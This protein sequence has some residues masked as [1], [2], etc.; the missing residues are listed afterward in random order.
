[1]LTAGL[2]AD[3]PG[4]PGDGG[5]GVDRTA[6]RDDV[7][8]SRAAGRVAS[9]AALGGGGLGARAFTAQVAAV[10]IELARL[11]RAADQI[12]RRGGGAGAV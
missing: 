6:T 2:E 12:R 7:P 8:A 5:A 10:R 1:M 9:A 11:A 3:L 4:G